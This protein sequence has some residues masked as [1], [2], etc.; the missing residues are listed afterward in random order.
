MATPSQAAS[1][2]TAPLK[3]LIIADRYILKHKIGHGSFG[4]IFL[5]SDLVT[6]ENVAIK[7]VRFFL[8]SLFGSVF[9]APFCRRVGGDFVFSPG[10]F[11]LVEHANNSMFILIV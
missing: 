1:S 2:S 11:R 6:G 3:E 10:E 8:R 5:G 9:W 4:Q 7:V